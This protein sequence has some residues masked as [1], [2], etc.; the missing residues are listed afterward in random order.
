MMPPAK[1]TNR[2]HRIVDGDTL[3]GLADLY[4]G[5]MARA[6]EIFDANRD[7]LSD[8]KLL[9]IGV[10]LKIPPTASRQSRP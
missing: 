6:N 9:P 1:E 2:T 3:E 8:P 5:S 10:E 4:L 7:V